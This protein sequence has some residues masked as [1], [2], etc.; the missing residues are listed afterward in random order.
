M[1]MQ[2]TAQI[3]L[4]LV[5]LSAGTLKLLHPADFLAEIEAYA[6]PAPHWVW[7]AIAAC[8]PW[9]E[10][11]VGVYLILN[12]WPETVRTLATLIFAVFF[13]LL[14]QA[15]IRGLNLSCGC[16]GTGAPVWMER[17]PIALGRALTLLATSIYCLND[18]KCASVSC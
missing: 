13:I 1:T 11:I 14:A 16:F 4:G 2:K 12:Y 18:R 17:P 5:L 8:F 7:Q 3:I 9:L 6:L 10:C 15:V